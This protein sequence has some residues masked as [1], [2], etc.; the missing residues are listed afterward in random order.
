MRLLLIFLLL[1]SGPPALTQEALNQFDEN[2]KRHGSWKGYYEDDPSQIKFEGTF[3]HG[4]ET[5]LFKFYQPG[6]KN[7]VATRLFSPDSDV[8][9]VKFL[10]QNGKVISEGRMRGTT[11]IGQWKYYHKNSDKLLMTEN[12]E[13]GILEGEKTTYFDN[14]RVA[15]ETFYRQG[16]LHGERILYSEKGVILEQM[17]YVNGEL[18]GPAKFF[19]GKGE[20]LSEGNYK[21]DRHHG[22][23]RYYENGEL[24]EEKKF[25]QN[26]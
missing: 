14:G 15:E 13:D 6:L 17:N 24:K 1:L 7:P 8:A 16:E 19:N 20:L 25:P 10:A 12:Y 23:W 9:E 18:H 3:E 5:G 26:R 11:R 22:I 21:N 2:G 4:K